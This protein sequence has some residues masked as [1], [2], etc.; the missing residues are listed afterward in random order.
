MTKL[1]IYNAHYDIFKTLLMIRKR[2]TCVM[3]STK[4]TIELRYHF[5]YLGGFI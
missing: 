3:E 1:E 2:F 4:L 5:A